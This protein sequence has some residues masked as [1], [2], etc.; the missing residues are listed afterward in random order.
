M[1][2]KL[3]KGGLMAGLAS[4]LIGCGTE[5][6]K[7]VDDFLLDSY[8]AGEVVKYPHSGSKYVLVHLKGPHE[9][10]PWDQSYGTPEALA[11]DSYIRPLKIEEGKVVEEIVDDYSL[12]GIYLEGSFVKDGMTERLSQEVL[13]DF[14]ARTMVRQAMKYGVDE[15]LFECGAVPTLKY[16]YPSESIE[17]RKTSTEAREDL[18]LEL[19]AERGNQLALTTFGS[20]HSWANNIENWN[21]ENPDQKFSLIEVTTRSYDHGK[22]VAKSSELFSRE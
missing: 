16:M 10:V 19:V 2:L 17:A 5:A 4:T 12:E 15:L 6:D 7:L 3:L 21:V 9:V 18:L 13:C 22:V 8:S 14:R 11:W 20:G 1:V